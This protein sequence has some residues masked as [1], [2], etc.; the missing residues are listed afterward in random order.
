MVKGS[1]VIVA[2]NLRRFRS[3]EV[4][5][6]KQEKEKRRSSWDVTHKERGGN[7]KGAS[8]LLYC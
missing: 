7:K 6:I 4:E 8:S 5:P 3:V 2:V 1:F